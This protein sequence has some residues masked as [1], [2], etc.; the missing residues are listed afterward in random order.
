MDA[1]QELR[2]IKNKIIGNPD[3]KSSIA[4]DSTLIRV[5]QCL[6][7]NYGTSTRIEAANVL[8][9]V[10][11][12]SDEAI[13]QLLRLHAVTNLLQAITGVDETTPKLLRVALGRALRTLI[14]SLAEYAGPQ[15]WGINPPVSQ[16]LRKDAQSVLEE[17]FQTPSLDIWLPLLQDQ[18]LYTF[19]CT[20]IA[21]GVRN[22][23]HRSLLCEWLPVA[24][25]SKLSK[26]K[27][28]WEK[29]PSF[30]ASSSSAMSPVVAPTYG[31]VLRQLLVPIYGKD[32]PP[33]ALLTSVEALTALLKDNPSACALLRSDSHANHTSSASSSSTDIPHGSTLHSILQHLQSA[34]SELRIATSHLLANYVKS[35]V[36][37]AVHLSGTLPS[38]TRA[39]ITSNINHTGTA[40]I[41]ESISSICIGILHLLTGFI[42][43]MDEPSATRTKACFILAKL[44]SDDRGITESAV[45]CGALRNLLAALEQQSSVGSTDQSDENLMDGASKPSMDENEE[46]DM[47]ESS[48]EL[49]LREGLFT[50]LASLCLAD[51]QIPRQVLEA[52]AAREQGPTAY[53]PSNNSNPFKQKPFLFTLLSRSITH[54]NLGVRY[55]ALQL[56][57]ALS[58]SLAVLR[59]GLQDSDVPSKVLQIV[60]NDIDHTFEDAEDTLVTDSEDV[61]DITQEKEHRAVLIMALMT[62]SNLVNDYAPFREASISHL[63]RWCHS[64][65]ESIRLNALWAL[66]NA[67]FNATSTEIA[68]TMGNITWDNI[69]RLAEDSDPQIREQAIILLQNI[70]MRDQDIVLAVE[71]LGNERLTKIL[72]HA[73]SSSDPKVTEHGIRLVNNI[74][75]GPDTCR[76]VVLSN[77]SVLTLL[78]NHLSHSLVVVRRAAASCIC[79]LLARRPFHHREF[80]D[81]G[82]EQAL[83]A[84]IGGRDRMAQSPTVHSST[85][86]HSLSTGSGFG[87]ALGAVGPFHSPAQKPGSAGPSTL[88]R[89]GGTGDITNTLQDGPGLMGRESD[90]EVLDAVKFALLVLERGKE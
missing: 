87:A 69:C 67:L 32:T 39:A 86:V 72:Q 89:T 1:Q 25:R 2:T 76:D 54:S 49:Q 79:E 18:S 19:V 84:V 8:Y 29:P 24:E 62:I 4:T 27:R 47:E 40:N 48:Q 70:T 88:A 23:A 60:S 15:I 33:A 34:D 61:E 11:S 66:R 28:G 90:R 46:E 64:S 50:C 5:L 45:E 74:T 63:A 38:H 12:G 71:N 6:D 36:S 16:R 43:V 44:V 80:R 51:N 81:I 14:C 68:S 26:G 65:D 56:V 78:R 17:F 83:R 55:S 75:T 30:G 9:S 82:I 13:S 7:Q 57:R 31:W 22:A 37:Y 3:A 73:L 77:K 35:S 41:P 58:R 53:Q 20:T 52:D 85:P 10:S 59:T 42:V 21:I